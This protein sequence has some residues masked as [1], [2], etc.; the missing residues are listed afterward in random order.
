MSKPFVPSP[1][2]HPPVESVFFSIRFVPSL[3]RH[4]PGQFSKQSTMEDLPNA[5]A[6]L[7][8][9]GCK[10]VPKTQEALPPSR[11]TPVLIDYVLYVKNPAYQPPLNSHG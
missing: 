3:S 8:D 2:H 7:T 6:L 1:S 9:P 5:E 4:H 11:I 10:L